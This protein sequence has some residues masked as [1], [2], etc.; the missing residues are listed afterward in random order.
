VPLGGAGMSVRLFVTDGGGVVDQEVEHRKHQMRVSMSC[1]WSGR[2]RSSGST[3]LLLLRLDI[4][5]DALDSQGG[6]IRQAL[7]GRLGPSRALRT[8]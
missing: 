3:Y 6:L 5:L 4:G 1:E 2:R 7:E 8:G